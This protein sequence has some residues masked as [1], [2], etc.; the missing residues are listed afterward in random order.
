MALSLTR[1]AEPGMSLLDVDTPALLIDLDAF[2]RNLKRMADRVAGTGVRL[3]PHAKTHKC[4]G[5]ACEQHFIPRAFVAY[6]FDR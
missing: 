3:R 4:D 5:E 6:G 1:P 2:E